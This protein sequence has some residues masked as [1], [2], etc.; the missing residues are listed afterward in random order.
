[1]YIC[2]VN[3][4]QEITNKTNKVMTKQ[5]FISLTG[6][7]TVSESEYKA[8]EEAYLMDD[9]MTKQEFCEMWL[10]LNGWKVQAIKAKKRAAKR[11]KMLEDDLEKMQKELEKFIDYVRFYVNI[12]T[13]S[14]E[15][16]ADYRA[17]R[18]RMEEIINSQKMQ[19]AM[20]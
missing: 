6:Y 3:K 17:E 4:K 12:D 15:M 13:C 11:K 14:D 1:M 18:K 8:I 19:I 7:E 5:E 16:V 9:N 2:S 20:L 10:N